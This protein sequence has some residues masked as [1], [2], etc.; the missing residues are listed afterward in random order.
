MS[1]ADAPNPRSALVPRSARVPRRARVPPSEHPPL[2]LKFRVRRAT[3]A[4]PD[5]ARLGRLCRA[6]LRG[7]GWTEPARL[8]ITL[9]DDEEMARLNG[10]QRGVR[11]PTDVL[12]FSLVEGSL[13]RFPLPPGEVRELGD[14]VLCYPRAV[15]QAEE[16]GHSVEREVGYLIAHGLLHILG[17]DHEEPAQRAAMR[18]RE[19]AALAAVGLVR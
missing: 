15:V 8:W 19:E 16:Y 7:E 14:V 18:D 6:V 10:R 11:R 17:H 13:D 5:R 9:V 4:R 12:S 3:G 1:D 2:D